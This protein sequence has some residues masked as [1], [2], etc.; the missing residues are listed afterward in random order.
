M[1]N[2]ASNVASPNFFNPVQQ[3]AYSLFRDAY[4]PLSQY[5]QFGQGAVPYGQQTLNNLYTNPYAS[6]FLQGATDA[7]LFGQQAG[8]TQFGVGQQQVGNAQDLYG[9]GKNLFG[10]GQSAMTAGQNLLPYATPL[11]QAGFDPQN[12]LYNRT[13]QQLQDQTRAAQAARGVA[14][15]PYGAGV[16]GSTLSNFNIDW[17]NNQLQ[18]MLQGAQGAGGLTGAGVGAMGA[19]AGMIGQGGRMYGEGAGLQNMGV[20][21]MAAAPGTLTQ[22]AMLPYATYQGIGQGQDQAL[23][24]YYQMLASGMGLSQAPLTAALGL[25]QGATSAQGVANNIFGNKLQQANLGWN[26]MGQLGQGFGSMFGQI[27][28][29]FGMGSMPYASAMGSEAAAGSGAGVMDA[30]MLLAL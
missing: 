9:Q 26:Q 28:N 22:A 10:V 23:Q 30:A 21:N 2:Y 25:G 29:P 24:Q 3:D 17:Q 27:G 19:G 1:Q 11:L 12:A 15:T 14:T 18:R 8:Q 4:N 20:S 16:E 13:L 6:R 7:S 5:S